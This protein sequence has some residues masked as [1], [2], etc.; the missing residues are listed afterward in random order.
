MICCYLG[1]YHRWIPRPLL[2]LV[3]SRYHHRAR[4]TSALLA[5][6]LS[7]GEVHWKAEELENPLC[8]NISILYF[9]R[10][11][12]EK[13]P[14]EEKRLTLVPEKG[15]EGELRVG[16]LHAHLVAVHEEGDGWIDHLWFKGFDRMLLID[17]N[18]KKMVNTH[19]EDLEILRARITMYNWVHSIV[20]SLGKMLDETEIVRDLGMNW[21]WAVH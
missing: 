2:L 5:G 6:Q 1:N 21:D 9:V 7:S 20:W 17:K 12:H 3:P 10:R 14:W 15:G 4:S 19:E 16:I 11:F 18:E 13:K 8:R